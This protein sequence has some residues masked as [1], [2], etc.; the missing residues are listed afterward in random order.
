MNK[1][2]PEVCR[3][4]AEALL[5]HVGKP[6][7]VED[8]EFLLNNW[9]NN[10]FNQYCEDCGTL[11]EAHGNIVWHFTVHPIRCEACRDMAYEAGYSWY[12]AEFVV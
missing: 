1:L 4:V 12:E 10:L 8:V 6:A 5:P 3:S 2:D 7:E 9:F 11:I